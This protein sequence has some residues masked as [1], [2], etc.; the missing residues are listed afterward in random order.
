MDSEGVI[1]LIMTV[2]LPGSGKSTWAKAW[3]LP[4]V[5]PDA[6]RAAM[7]SEALAEKN[8]IIPALERMVWSTA[9]LMAESLFL[10][11]HQKVVLDA[12]NHRRCYRD[13]W[14]MPF[15][16][17]AW[18]S[19]E[20]V[21]FDIPIETCLERRPGPLFEEIINRMHSEFDPVESDEGLITRLVDVGSSGGPVI[22]SSFT[23]V[24]F[25]S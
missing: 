2:G 8:K 9:H 6:I 14:A 7:Y 17:W 5:S 24:E 13:E 3:G 20:L 16:P 4:V 15:H 21:Y 11:G 1:K 25:G 22:K 19:R 18:N 10:A 23:L 12:C